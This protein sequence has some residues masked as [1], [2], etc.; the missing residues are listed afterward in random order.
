MIGKTHKKLLFL[1]TCNNSVVQFDK[2]S[3]I[4]GGH[5]FS[6]SMYYMYVAA[7]HTDMRPY[8]KV[9]RLVEPLGCKK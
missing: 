8:S 2:E 6:R 1:K 4:M 3:W 9:D 7:A 5:F